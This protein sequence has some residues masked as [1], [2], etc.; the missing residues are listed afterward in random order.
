MPEP[1]VTTVTTA[2]FLP[3]VH[4]TDLQPQ[5]R[6]PLNQPAQQGPD[7]PTERRGPVPGGP[8]EDPQPTLGP[9]LREGGGLVQ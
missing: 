8:T 1:H 9:G 4:A 2:H 6:R 7:G 3:G 5:A